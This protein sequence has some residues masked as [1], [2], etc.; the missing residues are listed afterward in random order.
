MVEL[1][2]KGKFQDARKKLDYL[3]YEYGMGGE[4]IISQIHREVISMKIPDK[5]KLH[6]IDKIGEYNFRLVQGGSERI[7]LEALLAQF[8]E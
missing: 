3:L 5:N 6:L 1:S 8:I 7:Q 4:D 2:M